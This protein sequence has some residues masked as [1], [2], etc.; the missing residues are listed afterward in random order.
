MKNMQ[1]LRVAAVMGIFFLATSPCLSVKTCQRDGNLMKR[2]RVQAIKQDILLRL[3]LDAEPTNPSNA[4]D[5]PIE[6]LKEF[7]AVQVVQELNHENKPCAI[8]DFNVQ[9]I[10]LISPKLVNKFKPNL[11][12]A[13]GGVNCISK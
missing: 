6:F 13:V 10:K 7:E 11:R 3:G 9:E 1:F 8:Q 2:R 4:S 5:I 12:G